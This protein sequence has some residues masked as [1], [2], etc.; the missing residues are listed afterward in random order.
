MNKLGLA[1][2]A[3]AVQFDADKLAQFIRSHALV[4]RIR[5]EHFSIRDKQDF[6]D[7]FMI[8]SYISINSVS[9]LVLQLL[10]S[11]L[12]DLKTISLSIMEGIFSIVTILFLT[13]PHH[14]GLVSSFSDSILELEINISTTWIF[15]IRARFLNFQ[16]QVFLSGKTCRESRN[17][18]TVFL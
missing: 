14:E 18:L 2:L 13:N 1:L 3:G 11:I 9:I 10:N 6:D 8:L 4:C 7:Q 16:F 17:Q 15:K 5:W 12:T